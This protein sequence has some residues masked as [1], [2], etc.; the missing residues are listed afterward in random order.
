M[1]EVEIS[2]RLQNSL[3]QFNISLADALILDE[4][5]LKQ[6]GFGNRSLIEITNLKKKI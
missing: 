6:I 2:T 4:W 1:E 5:R 3:K